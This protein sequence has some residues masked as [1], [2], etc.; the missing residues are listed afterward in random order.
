VAERCVRDERRCRSATGGAAQP[1]RVEGP[2][3][4]GRAAD[5]RA[6]TGD[7]Q[8]RR[9]A[10]GRAATGGASG[11]LSAARAREATGGRAAGQRKPDLGWMRR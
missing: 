6:A 2:I 4:D 8:P 9:A 7:E 3:R 5:G 10:D 1:R 11:A